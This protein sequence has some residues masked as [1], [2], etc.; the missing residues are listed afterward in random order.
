[1]EIWALNTKR[2]ERKLLSRRIVFVR[3]L[4]RIGAESCSGYGRGRSNNIKPETVMK[5]EKK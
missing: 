5:W 4:K 2:L 3:E 1:L